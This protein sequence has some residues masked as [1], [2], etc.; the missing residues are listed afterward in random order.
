MNN[1]Q[2]KE[3]YPLLGDPKQM[4]ESDNIYVIQEK[5]EKGKIY[6]FICPQCHT[7]FT[8][9]T[10][11]DEVKQIKCPECNT[12][13]YFSSTGKDRRLRTRVS[14]TTTYPKFGASGVL[15]WTVN[16]K[17]HNYP[18]LGGSTIIG[19]TDPSEPSDISIDDE[20]ASR[21][22]VEIVAVKGA[23]SGKF[24]FKLTVL[25]TTNAV[26]VNQNALYS[27]SSIYLNFGDTI[28]VGET[29]FTLSSGEEATL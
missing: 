27:G 20:M 19:R 22:S 1:L 29:I 15:T 18:L 2:N 16:N 24:L 21:H 26:F 13:I 8:A 25:R 17:I 7:H 4:F 6:S 9:F 23:R 12:F 5:A 14:P 11:D 10:D 3:D 28:K